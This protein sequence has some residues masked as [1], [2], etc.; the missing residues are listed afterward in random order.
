[1]KWW[2]KY[3]G[4]LFDCLLSLLIGC[5]ESIVT[6][7]GREA[8]NVPIHDPHNGLNTMTTN[9][10]P[11]KCSHADHA[12]YLVMMTLSCRAGSHDEHEILLISRSP[13]AL[14]RK[15][16]LYLQMHIQVVLIAANPH[17]KMLLSGNFG[18]NWVANAWKPWKPWIAC[19]LS[20]PMS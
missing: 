2:Y 13:G 7:H 1:M 5:C 9:C 12:C 20:M 17:W 6:Q 16:A 10:D 18:T 14:W 11:M 19:M 4:I 8:I 15:R 3:I